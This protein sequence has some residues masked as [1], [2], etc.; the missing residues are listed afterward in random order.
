MS[1]AKP[2]PINFSY[3][4]V[5]VVLSTFFLKKKITFLL[6]LEKMSRQYRCEKVWKISTLF[7]YYILAMKERDQ[8][9]AAGQVQDL[10]QQD[11]EAPEEG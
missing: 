5:V 3:N 6:V 9:A 7:D 10:A 2:R 4:V 8:T 11:G 1:A